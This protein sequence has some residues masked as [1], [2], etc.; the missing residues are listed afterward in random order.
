MIKLF[1][2][3]IFPVFLFA[4]FTVDKNG[5]KIYKAV[6]NII[7][8][9]HS[10][11]PSYLNSAGKSNLIITK[12]KEEESQTPAQREAYVKEQFILHKDLLGVKEIQKEKLDIEAIE[13]FNTLN[14]QIANEPIDIE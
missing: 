9:D 13:F 1:I 10:V 12:K 4:N 2:L 3:L 5:K 11:V 7:K 6:T 14:T 8:A